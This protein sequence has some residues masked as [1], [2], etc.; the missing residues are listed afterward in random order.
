MNVEF[1]F[2]PL[3][4]PLLELEV[5]IIINC[6]LF[7]VSFM[8]NVFQLFIYGKRITRML[9]KD[10]SSV[11]RQRGE[12]QNGGNKKTKASQIFRKK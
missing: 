3:S 4:S 8:G 12:S 6:R 11:I 2:S 10:N 5:P 1:F 9:S 7:S